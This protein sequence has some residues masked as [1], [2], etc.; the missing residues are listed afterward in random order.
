[1]SVSLLHAR[2]STGITHACSSSFPPVFH[3]VLFTLTHA[4]TCDM[5]GSNRSSCKARA[6]SLKS[7][8]WKHTTSFISRL[9]PGLRER[10][11]GGG[12]GEE[13]VTTAMAIPCTANTELRHSSDPGHHRHPRERGGRRRN[14]IDHCNGYAIVLYSKH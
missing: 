1:M 7:P 5:G 12:G 2:I 4:H 9:A 11:G 10:G 8:A 6:T 14:Y 13:E 3:T